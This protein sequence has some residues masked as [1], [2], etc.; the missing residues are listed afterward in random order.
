MADGLAVTGLDLAVGAT[1]ADGQQRDFVVEADE[2]LD[3]GAAAADAA[4]FLGVAP[5]LGHVLGGLD[6]GLSLA[7][8]RHDGLDHAGIADAA[9]DGLAQFLFGV[10]EPVRRGRQAKGLG[11]QAADALAVHGQLGGARRGRDAHGA[12][13]LQLD[14]QAGGDGLDF[15]D[16]DVRPFLVDDLAQGIRVRHGHHVGAVRHLLPRRVRVPVHGDDLHA[17]ALQGDDD[18]LA[19]L[20]GAEQHH[21]GG[22]G[23]QG[24]AKDGLEMRDM[25]RSWVKE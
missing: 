23:R 22:E 19:Q 24:R 14:Q 6:H 2:A 12:G 15:R 7:R 3:D 11:R 25:R 13:G 20:S 8:G 18:L 1:R 17:Q 5:A 4:A 10:D 9:V 21:S 16:N